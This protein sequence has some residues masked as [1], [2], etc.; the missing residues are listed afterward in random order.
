MRKGFTL[1]ELLVVISIVALLSSIVLAQLNSA[2][3][4]GRLAAARSFA[5]QAFRVAA[6]QALGIWDFED[7]SGTTVVDRSGNGNNGVLTSGLM[8]S[9][10]TYSGTGFSV[11]FDGANYMEVPYDL[12][13]A[14]TAAISFGAWFNASNLSGGRH[15]ISKTETGGYQLGINENTFCP[16]STLCALIH[17]SGT[18]QAVSYPISNIATGK[19]YYAFAT[20]DGDTLKLYL[21]GKEVSSN[22]TPSGNIVYAYN[23]PLCIGSEPNNTV[24]GTGY[25]FSG[26]IDEARVYGKAL[27]ASEVWNHYA[28]GLKH[29]GIKK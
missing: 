24:C 14:P 21:D 6:D 23:N 22:A 12:D 3:E 9:S 29:L 25:H 27:T 26:R 10:N 28:A 2:R 8:W 7:G 4:K 13:L 1:I 15:I 5:A 20:Y 18:Y 16:V 17:N 19:W 11:F